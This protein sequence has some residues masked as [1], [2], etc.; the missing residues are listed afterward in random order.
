MTTATAI[1]PITTETAPAVPEAPASGRTL[2]AAVAAASDV[3][4]L[5]SLHDP[6][7]DT[8]GPLLTAFVDAARRTAGRAGSPIGPTEAVSPVLRLRD[9][10]RLAQMTAAGPR[11]AITTAETAARLRSLQLA[12]RR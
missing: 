7:W 6:R 3:A 10:A 1:P 12:A 8:F 2:A 4:V 5:V 9:L 11:G